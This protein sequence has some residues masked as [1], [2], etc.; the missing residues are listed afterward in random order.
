MV[1]TRALRDHP[2]PATRAPAASRCL[3]VRL[4]PRNRSYPVALG[5]S[6]HICA[7]SA[8]NAAKARLVLQCFRIGMTAGVRHG[9]RFGDFW[10]AYS[11]LAP[12][13]DMLGAFNDLAVSLAP[14]LPS[15]R[16]RAG[17]DVADRPPH[18]ALRRSGRLR[19]SGRIRG[20]SRQGCHA[21]TS[22]AATAFI[23]RK[24]G[25]HSSVPKCLVTWR[26]A[27]GKNSAAP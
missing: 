10:M 4:A 21:R 15:R 23:H 24:V 8:Q 16:F 5:Q 2:G 17:S 14:A 12:A 3:D 1:V 11:E 18:G 9:R 22:R 13:Y 19:A 6:A 20:R 25:A 27:E 7:S 26:R